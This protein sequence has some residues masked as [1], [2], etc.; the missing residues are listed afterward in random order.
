[1]VV[2]FSNKNSSESTQQIHCQKFM[3]TPKERLYQSC[4]T[5]CESSDFGFLGFFFFFFSFLLTWDH[6]EV[7]VSSPPK[8]NTRFTYQ[9]SYIFL[10]RASTKVGK[11]FVNLKP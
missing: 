8:I 3:N 1:M 9:N 4:S 10:R 2:N 6:M 11:E 7:K 5:N